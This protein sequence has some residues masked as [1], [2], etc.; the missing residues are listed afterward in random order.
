MPGQTNPYNA[1]LQLF[2]EKY[3]NRDK[4]I[5]WGT[6]I[7]EKPLKI[8]TDDIVLE[9]NFIKFSESYYTRI[10]KGYNVTCTQGAITHNIYSALKFGDEVLMIRNMDRFVIIDKVVG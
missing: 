8:K 9:K 1:L 3:K 2:D 6:V 7:S 4:E 10:S 5:F